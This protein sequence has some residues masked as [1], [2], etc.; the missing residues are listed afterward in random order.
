VEV[1]V[2]VTK[3]GKFNGLI[4]RTE[5]MLNRKTLVPFRGKQASF[6]ANE[7]KRKK[8]ERKKMSIR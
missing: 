7:A 3:E 5:T 6:K 4:T 2:T 1:G 8:G